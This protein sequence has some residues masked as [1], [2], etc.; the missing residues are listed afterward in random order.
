MYEQHYRVAGEPVIVRNVETSEDAR[1]FIE[2]C[3]SNHNR[4]VAFDTET[5]GLDV[6]APGFRVRLVQFGTE[7]EAWVLPVDPAAGVGCA[8]QAAAREALVS[9]PFML[10]HNAK[11]DALAVS[12]HLGVDLVGLWRRITDTRILAHLLDPR[13]PQDPGGIGQGLKPLSARHVDPDAPDTQAGLY[14]EFRKLGHTK[15]TG[16]AAIPLGNELY[17]L[18]AG[19]DVILTCRLFGVLGPRVEFGGYGQLAEFEHAVALVCARMEARGFLLDVEYTES[20]AARLLDEADE[21]T[22][23]ARRFGVTSVN[24]PAQIA[25]ALEGMGETLTETTDPGA[26]KVDK[27]VL[28]PL[29]DL[30]R[31][32]QRIGAREP[33]PLADAVLRA[34]RASKWK[35]SY[36]DAM[37]ALRDVDGRIHPDITSL[38]ARTARMSISRPPLQQLPSGDWV[39][40]RAMQAEPGCVVGTVDYQAV[41]LRVLA[42]LSGDVQMTAAIHA[43]KDLHA[44]TAELIYGPDFTEYH[45]KVC[46][47]IGFGKVYGGGPD[48]L[49][50]QT[51]APLDQVQAAIRAYDR[52]YAGVRRYSTRLQNRAEWGAREVITPAG[53]RL[54]LDRRRLY[55][56]TN[57]VVQSSARDVLAEALLRLDE[58]GLT[59]FLRLPV[60][61][62]VVFVAPA[63]DAPDV[64]REIQAAMTVDDFYGVPLSTDLDIGGRTWGSLY[65]AAA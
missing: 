63:A 43:G 22:A 61:D 1:A 64:G 44:F 25:A 26:L 65:G 9:L 6:Y 34:K 23:A 32:W 5:T 17:T 41:E 7:R 55:A 39:I 2:W 46:K 30:D 13:G 42:A 51:G 10:A 19:L 49:A 15:E 4:P 62:E 29:A 40:R 11:F 47:G 8:P 27:E 20:L 45:R 60:H 57:Y 12:A 52:A 24:A 38:A 50:R 16:W 58:R 35:T 14:G 33:N 31:K 48:T 37:L 54:P 3:R 56:A 59:E 18:Y 36:A 28:L 53:R 21:W